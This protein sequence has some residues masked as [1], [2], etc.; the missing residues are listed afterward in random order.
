MSEGRKEGQALL[1]IFPRIERV[2]LPKDLRPD[3]DDND[4][5]CVYTPGQTLFS[6]SPAI[7]AR[8]AELGENVAAPISMQEDDSD[9]RADDASIG[10]RTNS[11]TSHAN[12]TYPR[13]ASPL[14]PLTRT[15]SRRGEALN[16]VDNI[17]RDVDNRHHGRGNRWNL[18]A[19]NGS[20]S[21][22]H[23][24]TNSHKEPED[25]TAAGPKAATAN[26]DQA[27][28]HPTGS[29]PTQS[30]AHSRAATPQLSRQTTAD[31]TSSAGNEEA[32]QEAKAGGV[33]DWGDAGGNVPGAFGGRGDGW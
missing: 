11:V 22:H 8:R 1:S 28:D 25:E 4:V 14:V 12:Q 20:S 9:A 3:D 17:S 6:N 33:P 2:A 30:P 31:S 27:S 7:L 16:H 13:T 5:E 18:D 32:Y 15:R 24:I 29:S 26:S 21:R 10:S 23:S 19:D